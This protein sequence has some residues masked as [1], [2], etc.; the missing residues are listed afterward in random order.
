MGRMSI[1]RRHRRTPF[2]YGLA[3]WFAAVIATCVI[4][5][6]W[7]V[8]VPGLSRA[9][10]LVPVVPDAAGYSPILP[11]AA[12]C[13]RLVRLE[14]RDVVVNTCGQCRNVQILRSRGGSGL[15]ELRTFRVEQQSR[16]AL[17]YK[18]PGN[19]RISSDEA[20]APETVESYQ[21]SRAVA[22]ATAQCI[23]IGKVAR[24]YVVL[25]RCPKCRST[26]MRWTYPDG[27]EK[28]FPLAIDARKSVAVPKGS[29]LGIS[30]V[31][32]EACKG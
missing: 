22:E 29:E 7:I 25:N 11:V 2:P 31:H 30:V 19:T 13:A 8:A 17:P 26:V 12:G 5:S 24:G 9:G 18:G 20:C 23:L 32:E 6:F 10:S 4:V 28:N 3:R 15:P 1:K 27:T 16:L 21:D 14:G